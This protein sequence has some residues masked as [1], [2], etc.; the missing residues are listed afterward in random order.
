[1][2]RPLNAEGLTTLKHCVIWYNDLLVGL[3]KG[4]EKLNFSFM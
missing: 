2:G 4:I 1:M 3:S